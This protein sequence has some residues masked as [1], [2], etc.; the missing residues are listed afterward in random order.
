MQCGITMTPAPTVGPSD[1]PVNRGGLCAKG[2]SADELLGHPD[3][4]TTPLVRSVAGDRRSPLRPVGWDE[5]LGLV[6][7]AIRRSQQAYG[8]DSVGCFGGGGLTNEKACQRRG[9]AAAHL[10][11]QG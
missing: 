9:C 3:R 5:A 4:L 2:W 1:F 10:P 8:T 11:R 7:A 6:A